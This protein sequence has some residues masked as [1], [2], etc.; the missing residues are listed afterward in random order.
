MHI[1]LCPSVLHINTGYLMISAILDHDKY[2]RR[3]VLTNEEREALGV[4][5]SSRFDQVS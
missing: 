5:I 4:D 2:D 3:K 1:F